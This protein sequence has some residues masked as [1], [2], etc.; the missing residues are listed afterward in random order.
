MHSTLWYITV[1]YIQYIRYTPTVAYFILHKIA[2]STLYQADKM[3]VHSVVMYVAG[4]EP[5]L[6]AWC[7]VQ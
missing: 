1:Q 2:D 7:H 4:N 6:Q 3:G 5:F